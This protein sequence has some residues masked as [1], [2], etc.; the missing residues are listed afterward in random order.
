MVPFY[1]IISPEF[2]F[3][4]SI[5]TK[6][7]PP[8]ATMKTVCFAKFIAMVDNYERSRKPILVR[9]DKERM[10]RKP[11]WES[12]DHRFPRMIEFLQSSALYVNTSGDPTQ[13]T[14][15]L[16]I[17]I[18]R[19]RLASISIKARKCRKPER[20]PVNF[21]ARWF[22]AD[23]AKEKKNLP[24]DSR[25]MIHEFRRFRSQIHLKTPNAIM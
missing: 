24:R 8:A 11:G 6:G 9:S 18:D 21:C 5:Y 22:N 17:V 2:Y 7:R 4:L 20:A 19:S 1:F 23:C 12:G 3:L 25:A 13:S 14:T 16:S 10:R 15:C